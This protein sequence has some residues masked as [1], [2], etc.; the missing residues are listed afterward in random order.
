MVLLCCLSHPTGGTAWLLASKRRPSQWLWTVRR[1][2]L[3]HSAEVTTQSLTQMA[4][5]SSA[6][7]S[8]TRKFLRQEKLFYKNTGRYNP[9][10]LWFVNQC[11]PRINSQKKKWY[12]SWADILSEGRPCTFFTPKGCIIVPKWYILVSFRIIVCIIK[13]A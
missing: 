8:W 11:R 3:N 7:E 1:R 9:S 12:N 6:P 4:S 13:G 5:L 2:S 10:Q